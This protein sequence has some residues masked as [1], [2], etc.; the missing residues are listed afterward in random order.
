MQ[1]R[2]LALSPAYASAGGDELDIPIFQLLLL[3]TSLKD[4]CDARLCAPRDLH[5]WFLADQSRLIR[6]HGDE[7]S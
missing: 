4:S 2:M 6:K 5:T 3:T 1:P 7:F